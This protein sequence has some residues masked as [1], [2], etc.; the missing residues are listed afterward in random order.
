VPKII[1]LAALTA[2]PSAAF[3]KSLYVGTNISL[4][5]SNPIPVGQALDAFTL[6]AVGANG[7]IPNTF[8]SSNSGQG[9]TGITTVG[10][11]LA[12][13]WEFNASPTPT[14]TLIMPGD[15]PQQIDTHF[16]V[17]SNAIFSAVA[18]QENRL[19]ANPAEHPYAGFGNALWGTFA[20][21]SQSAS[22][23]D[24]AY[25]VVPLNTTVQFNFQLAAAGF[26]A[27]S[28]NTSW[29]LTFPAGDV[30]MDGIVNGQDIAVVATNWLQ[31]ARYGDA[32]GDGIVNGQDIAMIASNWLATGGGGTSV[33][34]PAAAAMVISAAAAA[35]AALQRRAR[36]H[37]LIRSPGE[38]RGRA[39]AD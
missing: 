17:D 12:Q 4:I 38:H 9:G 18:P 34:E 24:F 35:L 6:T 37:R 21:G 13:V 31:N 32:N 30:N 5:A 39:A 11:N 29:T 7:A 27:E 20:M 15:I 23:W 2:W 16:L 1:L 28:I 19:V 36:R 14:N 10:N 26:P 8:D 33:P 22:N 25:V 3:A